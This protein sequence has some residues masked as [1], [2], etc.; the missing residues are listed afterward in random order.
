MDESKRSDP[1]PDINKTVIPVIRMSHEFD[2]IDSSPNIKPATIVRE[3]EDSRKHEIPCQPTEHHNNSAEA[4]N[5]SGTPIENKYLVNNKLLNCANLRGSRGSLISSDV[6]SECSDLDDMFLEPENRLHNITDIAFAE[7]CTTS[8]NS[9]IPPASPT[10]EIDLSDD[11]PLVAAESKSTVVLPAAG[12]AS[13]TEHTTE[14]RRA[15]GSRE[16]LKPRQMQNLTLK[17]TGTIPKSHSSPSLNEM[18]CFG[19]RGEDYYRNCAQI[20]AEAKERERVKDYK[21][22]NEMLHSAV[23]ILIAGV[24]QDPDP[25]RREGELV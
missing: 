20:V 22:A 19:F 17:Y 2:D 18:G 12:A 16:N 21:G 3:V 5:L 1:I 15:S 25:M 6:S 23:E 10:F 7:D 14:H 11:G 13:A 8:Y 4:E 24:Q 9:D